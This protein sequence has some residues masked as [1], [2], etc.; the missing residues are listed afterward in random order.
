VTLS[1]GP[2][3][4]LLLGGFEVWS[5]GE[6]LRGFESQKVRA[7]LAYLAL[8]RGKP[9]GRDHLAG[10][11]WGEKDPD[12]ARRNLRQ[13]IYNLKETL[14]EERAPRPLLLID[15]HEL[16]FSADSDAWVDVEAFEHAAGAGAVSGRTGFHDLVG[17]AQLYRGDLLA[18][19][20][21]KE[22]G[23]FEEWLITAQERLRESAL[24]TLRTLVASY[25]SRGEYR[26]GIR[27]ARRLVAMDPLSE[28]A[29]RDLLRLYELAGHRGRA[30]AHYAELCDLLR[31]ELGVAPLA[32]TQA[33]YESI[34]A[35]AL[36][37]EGAVVK[38]ES[39]GPIVPLV[40]RA[41]AFDQLAECWQAV[42]EGAFQTT[43]LVG[44]EGI[45]KTRLVRSFLDAATTRA[46][47]A[48]LTGTCREQPLQRRHG[49]LTEALRQALPDDSTGPGSALGRLPV[50]TRD[51]LARLFPELGAARSGVPAGSPS[52]NGEEL[53]E[54]VAELLDELSRTNSGTGDETPNEPVVLF[55]DDLQ[56]ADAGTLSVVAELP[57]W[58]PGSRVWLVG[59]FDPAGLADDHPLLALA[60]RDGDGVVTSVELERLDSAALAELATSIVDVRDSAAI[61][62]LLAT[63]S[64]G[65]PLTVVSLLNSMWD[66]GDLAVDAEGRGRFRGD[67]ERWRKPASDG[68][69]AALLRRVRRLPTST[70]RLA[71]MAAVIGQRFDSDLLARAEDEHPAVVETGLGLLLERWLVRQHRERWNA[72]GLESSLVLWSRGARRGPFQFDPPRLRAALYRDLHPLRRQVLHRQI[73]DALVAM[74]AGHAESPVEDLAHHYLEACAWER[75]LEYLGLA[76]DRALAARDPAGARSC[77]QRALQV[78]ERLQQQAD[79]DRDRARWRQEQQ[80]LAALLIGPPDNAA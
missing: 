16:R 46:R 73:A 7:L 12:A 49:A 77:W 71:T 26:L 69:D 9:L 48:V 42:V 57:R 10:L 67:P 4:I 76:A 35:D 64:Q 14:R 25:S 78:V 36:R 55:L 2:L 18:G 37:V 24:E 3:R 60:R 72:R 30:L 31:R 80:R 65:L 43:L 74:H 44:E 68:L 59:A 19:L 34:L 28:E 11:F 39:L 32:E 52:A 33:L 56:W 53:A 61:A 54:A 38:P 58:L 5:G 47:F 8:H 20:L 29:H 22:C 17:A 79:G 66:E 13:A 75:A 70:R 63:A 21:L 15:A 6:Q 51:A 41:T 40:G 1:A 27:H 50:E 45:G 23:D 62:E